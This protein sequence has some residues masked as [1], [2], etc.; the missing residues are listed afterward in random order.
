MNEDR[1]SEKE[2]Q[3][4]KQLS[5]EAEMPDDLEQKVIQRLRDSGLI[6]EK[7]KR[8]YL[9]WALPIAA[10]IAFLAGIFFERS[11]NSRSIQEYKNGYALILRQDDQFQPIASKEVFEE[12]ANWTKTQQT[13]GITITGQE[14]VSETI[15]VKQGKAAKTNP[16]QI[17]TG[18]FIIE[19]TSLEQAIDIAKD[20][21]HL[22]Y[23][24]SIEI[25]AF[26][27]R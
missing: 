24:G 9:A 22:K 25:K 8:N 7:F 20:N 27:Y 14:L 12:Y 17:I 5:K 16:D 6:K 3:L 2:K 15:I 1:L 23:G 10:S 19:A 21:P 13:A 4:Y 11:G 26:K 18:Y